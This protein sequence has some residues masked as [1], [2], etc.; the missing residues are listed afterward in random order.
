MQSEHD[1]PPERAS[2]PGVVEAIDRKQF[3]IVFAI[4]AALTACVCAVALPDVLWIN[5]LGL[6]VPLGILA[7]SA[8]GLVGGMRRGKIRFADFGTREGRFVAIIWFSTAIFVAVTE[9]PHALFE[10]REI[11]R[12]REF[13]TAEQISFAVE[14]GGKRIGLDGGESRQLARLLSQAEVVYPTREVDLVRLNL[15]VR[16]QE[17]R[18]FKYDGAVPEHHKDD[19]GLS[20]GSSHILVKGGGAWLRELLAR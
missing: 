17:G 13:G 8:A 16:L 2:R 9:L 18:E 15:I 19:V 20:A 12:V 3:A 1:A 14:S 5:K 11:N 7:G 4:T 10:Q 6:V